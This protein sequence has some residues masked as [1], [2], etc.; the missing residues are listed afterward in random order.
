[1]QR[2]VSQSLGTEVWETRLLETYDMLSADEAL[3]E[4]QT[5]KGAFQV[6]KSRSGACSVY[7][8]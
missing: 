6:M 5:P 7:P 2:L 1:M 3:Y 8:A 4:V